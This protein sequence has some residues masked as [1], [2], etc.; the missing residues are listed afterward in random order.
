MP[1]Q[2]VYDD[3]R[4]F[5]G[6][7]AMRAAGSGYNEALEQPAL[8]A[9]LPVVEGADAVDLGCG[10]GALSRLLV[11]EGARSVLAVD[12]SA[13]MLQLAAAHPADAR[14]R[15]VQAFAE[16][17][18]LAEASVDLVVSSLALHYVADLRLLLRRVGSWLRPG[19]T[20][21]AS[22]EHPVVTAAP[23]R[24]CA[25]GWVVAGY[26]DEGPRYTRWFVE[27]VVKHH[28]TLSTV[29]GAVLDAGLV[30]SALVE[31]TPD[32]GQLAD[33]PDLA[34]HRQRPPLLLVRAQRP[35]GGA[36]PGPR[37]ARCHGG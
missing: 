34:V 17:L 36:Q 11:H 37:R 25:N 29:V 21:V 5:A 23:G 27:D 15:F 30:L 8:R 3:Q 1:G 13:R 33:R 6:Y 7:Q 32:P 24:P 20:F 22:M 35:A 2:N 12:P 14:V 31:P 16:D 10:D 19:G 9:L 18:E 26:A 28:R 4:F